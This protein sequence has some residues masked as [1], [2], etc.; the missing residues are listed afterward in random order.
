MK[1]DNDKGLD[2]WS[3]D[4]VISR[5]KLRCAVLLRA[6]KILTLS[7]D[8]H[9]FSKNKMLMRSFIANKFFQYFHVISLKMNTKKKRKSL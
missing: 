6:D 4:Q 8:D 1:K 9:Y 3:N 7:R 5:T 2:E